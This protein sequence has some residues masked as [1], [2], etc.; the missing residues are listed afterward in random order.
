MIQKP[1]VWAKVNRG[2]VSTRGLVSY[3]PFYERGGLWAHDP[4]NGVYHRAD[5]VNGPVWSPAGMDGPC[6]SFDGTDDYVKTTRNDISLLTNT[7]TPHTYLAWINPTRV[8]ATRQSIISVGEFNDVNW[9][10]VLM[11]D[12][13]TG[14]LSWAVDPAA[15]TVSS[16]MFVA[17]NKWQFVAMVR[18][19][20]DVRFFLGATRVVVSNAT[21]NGI[22]ADPILV[23]AAARNGALGS[24]Y[25]A[26]K[27]GASMVYNRA[28]TDTEVLRLL[29]DPY[30]VYMGREEVAPVTAGGSTFFVTFTMTAADAVASTSVANAVGAT[31]SQTSTATYSLAA[32]DKSRCH[33]QYADRQHMVGNFDR[34]MRGDSQ[35]DDLEH[36][37]LP[38][39]ERGQCRPHESRRR[40]D[41]DDLCVLRVRAT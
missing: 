11:I 9:S 2:H 7:A 14:E 29:A 33:P 27:I 25:F 30:S 40:R 38:D 20:S 6:L 31:L 12:P 17:A 37:F 18:T 26:G 5:L 35:R 15:A 1:P 34:S 4:V 36:A 13:A 3:L 16:G 10:S 21:A 22:G 19:A 23:G 32:V 41:A 28:L 39:G 24:F 8:G